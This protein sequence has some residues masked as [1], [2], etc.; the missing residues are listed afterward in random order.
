MNK[1]NRILEV[2]LHL[3]FLV[4]FVLSV[5]H[6]KER[7]FADSA[8]F[9][10]HAVNAEWFH[11][12]HQRLLLGF[13][14]IFP[15][16][17]SWFALPLKY[18]LLSYSLGIE[19]LYY[20][21][22]LFLAYGLKDKAAAWGLVL[23]H[24]IGQLWLFY[25]PSLESCH[26]AALAIVLYAVLR[27]TNASKDDKWLILLLL[28]E[29]LVLFSHPANMLFVPIII[30]FDV[31]HSKWKARIH[32][33]MTAFFLIGL[34]LRFALISEYD[35]AN[36]ESTEGSFVE[37]AFSSSSWSFFTAI[38]TSYYFDLMLLLLAN[39]VFLLVTKAIKQALLLVFSFFGFSILIQALKPI[40]GFYFFV[41]SSLVP[42]VFV[43]VFFFVFSFM[44]QLKGQAK[45]V[46]PLLLFG[47]I[48][49]RIFWIVDFGEKFEMR[50]NQMDQV[51]DQ[52]QQQYNS[53]YILQKENI[54]KEYSMPTWANPIEGLIF[55]ALDGPEASVSLITQEDLDYEQNK[56]NL[57]DSS[58][59]LRK[60]DLMDYQALNSAYFKLRKV[61]YQKLNTA[62]FQL[63]PEEFAKH[64]KV[65]VLEGQLLQFKSSD[66]TASIKVQILNPTKF[67][68]PSASDSELFIACHWYK[69]DGEL[70]LW[71]GR[72]NLLEVDV[73]GEFEQ[74]ITV[75]LPQEKGGYYL[76]PDL[77][78]EGKMWYQ[79]SEQYRVEVL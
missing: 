35:Q 77:V 14:Q 71:D 45:T 36:L 6:Y 15:V 30:L 27:K 9:F 3:V 7:L 54:N 75:N 12:E 59:V 49:F 44:T 63:A 78:I 62:S 34:F 37:K 18:L 53:K 79:F 74:H 73:K 66:S 19:V 40:E 22:F 11:I 2:G 48:G 72:R 69:A 26:A 65:K 5:L 52:A 16:I 31:L 17:G 25:V 39:L 24:L 57:N 33:S 47:I 67:P 38:V 68:L 51:V 32:I 8:Y 28:L 41:E 29:W 76:Q 21:L 56:R 4:L 61:P 70:L 60:F 46:V 64:V 10:F 1:L 55:S 23:V 43:G 42:L 13:S 50:K 58:F 20:F